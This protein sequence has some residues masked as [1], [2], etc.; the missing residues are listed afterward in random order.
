MRFLVISLD[1]IHTHRQPYRQTHDTWE[2]PGRLWDGMNVSEN[3]T[4]DFVAD[5]LY[6][7]QL[8]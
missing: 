3:K 8:N 7:S 1:A 5:I 4:L 2:L 6:V